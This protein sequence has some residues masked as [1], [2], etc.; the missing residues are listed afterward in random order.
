V[1][2]IDDEKIAIVGPINGTTWGAIRGIQGTTIATHASGASVVQVSGGIYDVA[3][4]G[5]LFLF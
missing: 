3:N 4:F 1:V 5:Y 2:Q